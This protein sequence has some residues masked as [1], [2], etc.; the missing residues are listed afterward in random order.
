MLVTSPLMCGVTTWDIY[1]A[2]MQR[3]YADAPDDRIQSHVVQIDQQN[4]EV[5][6]LFCLHMMTACWAGQHE[7][8]FLQKVR[9]PM[10][11]SINIRAILAFLLEHGS[12]TGEAEAEK[13][14]NEVLS[15]QEYERAVEIACVLLAHPQGV[16]PHW[17]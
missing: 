5:Q 11:K 14:L 1:N 7:A 15:L 9:A 16:A 6:Q 2:L 4:R 10:M 13:L 3:A 8:A 17:R 12:L